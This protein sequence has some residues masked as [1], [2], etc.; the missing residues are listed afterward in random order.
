M[1]IVRY[2]SYRVRCD[3]DWKG[4]AGKAE[5]KETEETEI[6]ENLKHSNC[7]VFWC[8]LFCGLSLGIG[9]PERIY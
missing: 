3:S 7:S 1:R 5:G 2:D 9:G 4:R 8:Q 6:T